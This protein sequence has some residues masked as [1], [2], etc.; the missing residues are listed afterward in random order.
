M[1]R[2]ASEFDMGITIGLDARRLEFAKD[3]IVV[4][5]APTADVSLPEAAQLAERHAVIR[6]VAG[7]WLIESQQDGALRVADGRP[8]KV[9]WL[10]PGDSIQLSDSGPT[11]IFEPPAGALSP[12][13]PSVEILPEDSGPIRLA[14]PIPAYSPPSPPP[15]FPVATLAADDDQIVIPPGFDL[16]GER[17]PEKPLPRKRAQTAVEAAAEMPAAREKS[18]NPWR[19]IGIAAACVFVIYVSWRALTSSTPRPQDVV[20]SPSVPAVV[21]HDN[22]PR[23]EPPVTKPDEKQINP[24]PAAAGVPT[25]EQL[26]DAI[27]LVLLSAP[28]RDQT[29]RLGTAWAVDKRKLVTSAAVGQGILQLQEQLPQIAVKRGDDSAAVKIVQVRLHPEYQK[30]AAEVAAAQSELD[31]LQPADPDDEKS[32]TPVVDDETRKKLAT[33]QENLLEAL[34]RQL[35]FDLAI[36][37]V[38]GDLPMAIKV[39]ADIAGVRPGASVRLLGMPFPVDEFLV[40]PDALLAVTGATGQVQAKI[41]GDDQGVVRWLVKFRDAKPADNWSGSAVVN[42]RGELIGVYSRPTPPPTLLDD[43]YV[44]STHEVISIERLKD[45]R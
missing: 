15:P 19:S 36:L 14:A 43:D 5:R 7:K 6:K 24:P 41:A 11:L 39:A 33:V 13:I 8:T 12:A 3:E 38:E 28:D 23:V 20:I 31:D 22:L 27:Y 18:E 29:Y 25:I 32:E 4:G 40:D 42:S 16:D 34:Q 1:T 30:I 45:I 17:D 37:D 2:K 44:P 26:T 9:A 21:P 10:S 35:D